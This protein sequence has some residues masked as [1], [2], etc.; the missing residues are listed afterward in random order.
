MW[1]VLVVECLL[2]RGNV[3][4]GG[5]GGGPGGPVGRRRGVFWGLRLPPGNKDDTSNLAE[6]RYC[7]ARRGCPVV[8]NGRGGG[9]RRG[10]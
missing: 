10:A 7:A 6:R 3:P 2:N 9:R 1:P 5:H 4:G 8:G